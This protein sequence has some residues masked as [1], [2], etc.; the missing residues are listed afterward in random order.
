MLITPLYTRLQGMAEHEPLPGASGEKV[1]A[2]VLGVG[3]NVSQGI[4]KALSM[5]ALQVRVV[6]A[7]VTPRAA[8]LYLA[9]RA[10]VSPY[11][12]DPAFFA[13]LVEVC[14]REGVDVVLS[15]VEPV[16]SVLASKAGELRERTGAVAVVS[17]PGT[18]GVGMDK[19][20][21][22]QWLAENGLNSPR[23]AEAADARAVTALAEEIGLPLVAKPRAGKGG[24]GVMLVESEADLEWAKSRSD[25][26]VQELLG[27]PDTEYTVGCFSD[28]AGRVRG[29]MAMRRTL[30]DG[31]TVT[32]EAGSFPEVSA[33][34]GRIAAALQPSGPCNVQLRIHEGKPV[35]FEINVRFSGTTPIRTRLGFN[36]VEA[37]IRH[38]AL[39]H[40]ATD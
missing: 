27:D 25:Y 29:T 7:C 9:D 24:H 2:L 39:G 34:A 36:E 35:C 3:G 23:T 37:A 10:F 18:L 20:K 19:L 1:T 12:T 15:G 17:E 16:L 26:V 13:W 33:E 6:A 38:Y 31:T 30:Q 4:Q 11:A 8:G 28:S 14:E 5:G 22:A 40:E 21:T 32:A